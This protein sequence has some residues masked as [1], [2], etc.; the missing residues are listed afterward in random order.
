MK[1]PQQLQDGPNHAISVSQRAVQPF[2]RL[3]YVDRLDSSPSE[4][5]DFSRLLEY[6]KILFRHKGTLFVFTLLGGLPIIINSLYQTP[7]YRARASLEIQGLQESS[8]DARGFNTV[9]SLTDIQTQ[10][11]ILQSKSLLG[12]VMAKMTSP[13]KP[14]QGDKREAGEGDAPGQQ[15]SPRRAALGMALGS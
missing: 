1:H 8:L 10:V 14:N 2:H 6:W 11:N 3:P 12:R 5:T 7:V 4:E 13:S 15:V 9:N